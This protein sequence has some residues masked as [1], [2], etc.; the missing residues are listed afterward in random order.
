MTLK[1]RIYSGFFI[2]NS[3]K[4]NVLIANAVILELTENIV[5]IWLT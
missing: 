2:F 5:L 3:M 4:I 1:A